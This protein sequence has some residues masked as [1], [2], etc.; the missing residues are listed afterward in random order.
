MRNK[1]LFLLG[2]IAL[3]AMLAGCGDSS[4]TYVVTGE[5]TLDGEPLPTKGSIILRNVPPDQDVTRAQII[6][7][8]FSLRATEGQKRVEINAAR[9]VPGETNAY[10]APLVQ[11]YVPR[12]YNADSV[13][14]EEVSATE[15]NHFV[16]ELKTDG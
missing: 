1:L 8:R 7:G 12:K 3:A 11:P 2:W 9:E 15:K 13:L 4:G 5:V 6:D 10:G 16:F 14:A